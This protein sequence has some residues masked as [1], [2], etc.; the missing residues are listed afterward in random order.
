MSHYQVRH[1]PFFF[2]GF[3]THIMFFHFFMTFYDSSEYAV[4]EGTFLQD[5]K[6]KGNFFM[7][8]DDD[9]LTPRDRISDNMLRRM[10]DGSDLGSVDRDISGTHNHDMSHSNLR[11]SW[12]LEDFPLASVYTPLQVFRN[13]FDR[14]TAL[15]KGTIFSELDL[16]FMGETVMKGGNCRG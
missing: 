2:Y 16:P 13:L 10:L 5:N 8:L 14:E 7:Y 12:G 3:I 11:H 4:Y 15:S 1:H 6:Q 9:T